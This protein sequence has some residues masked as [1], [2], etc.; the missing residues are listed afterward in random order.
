M[1]LQTRTIELNGF[2]L[3]LI[4][5]VGLKRLYLRYYPHT[6]QIKVTYNVNVSETELMHFINSKLSKLAPKIKA[7]EA[8]QQE[9]KIDYKNRDKLKIWGKE[10]QLEVRES[11]HN[12]HI[13]QQE[14]KIYLFV[15]NNCTAKGRERFVLTCLR[16]CFLA[17]VEELSS[18][19]EKRCQVKASTYHAKVMKTRWGSCNVVNKSINLNLCLIHKEPAC[20]E[21]VMIHELVH[22]Y[23]KRHNEHF[24][25]LLTKFCPNWRDLKLKLESE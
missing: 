6:G 8:R 22:L 15:P 12:Y 25:A 14:D 18:E 1:L 23:E 17:K 16:A 21:Y 11:G 10:Y 2:Q 19:L 9:G 24:Y 3:T 5:K 7:S 20:L 4:P 13:C